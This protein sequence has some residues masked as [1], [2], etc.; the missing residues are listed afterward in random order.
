MVVRSGWIGNLL[1]FHLQTLASPLAASTATIKQHWENLIPTLVAN[2]EGNKMIVQ[3][4]STT[5]ALEMFHPLFHLGVTKLYLQEDQSHCIQDWRHPERPKQ[6]KGHD[7]MA[8]P[9]STR[10]PQAPPCRLIKT[11]ST[12]RHLLHLFHRTGT[13]LVF[14]NH[15]L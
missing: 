2:N 3:S 14:L 11:C 15:F 12:L 13:P 6:I 10:K 8:T 1:D 9:L 7:P 4:S 5:A